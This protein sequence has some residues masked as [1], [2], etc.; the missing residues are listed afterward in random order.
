MDSNTCP[1]P[2]FPDSLELCAKPYS[3]NLEI[4]FSVAVSV[5]MVTVVGSIFLACSQLKKDKAAFRGS[6]IFL[7]GLSFGAVM[8]LVAIL[9]WPLNNTNGTCMAKPVFL[10]LA[11]VFMIGM[12]A[13]RVV[14][15]WFYLVF[16]P[17]LRLNRI[18]DLNQSKLTRYDTLIVVGL[19][20]L[21]ESILLV[22]LYSVDEYRPT[23][24]CKNY[25]DS[26]NEVYSSCNMNRDFIFILIALKCIPALTIMTL[27]FI[28]IKKLRKHGEILGVP[29]AEV[30][31][32][33]YIAL[34][35]YSVFIFIFMAGILTVKQEELI[36]SSEARNNYY[37]FRTITFILAAFN[38]CL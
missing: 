7:V 19:V 26:S 32:F 1:H 17:K 2:D 12:L 8:L 25:T 35:M 16:R 33:Y 37:V 36:T 22:V 4:I 24:F 13:A 20:L 10:V 23:C 14:K 3:T 15:V 29:R 30:A 21:V 5:I 11:V 34:T 31:D 27:T 18:M 38:R 6:F 28:T 9:L